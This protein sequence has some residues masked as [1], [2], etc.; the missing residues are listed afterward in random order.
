MKVYYCNE[1]DPCPP[2]CQAVTLMA[3][4]IS[5]GV[6]VSVIRCDFPASVVMEMAV[7]G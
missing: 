4:V 1:D 2:T 5:L 7:S 6:K 3:A